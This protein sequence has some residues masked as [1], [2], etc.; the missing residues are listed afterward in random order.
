MPRKSIPDDI[1]ASL[2]APLGRLAGLDPFTR[3]IV[4]TEVNDAL[5]D[6]QSEI[7]SLRRSAVR[8]LRVQGH[9]LREIADVVGVKPQRIHQIEGGYDRTE[10][11]ERAKKS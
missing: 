9:T 7:A 11:R 5:L 10:K 2:A 3:L 1:R 8:E 6:A 4:A